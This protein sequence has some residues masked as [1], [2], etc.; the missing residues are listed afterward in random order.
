MMRFFA[1]FAG[2]WFCKACLRLAPCDVALFFGFRAEGPAIYLA[3]PEGLGI[4]D[5]FAH[6]GL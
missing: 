6:P 4:D 1:E 3:Q 5:F 2:L